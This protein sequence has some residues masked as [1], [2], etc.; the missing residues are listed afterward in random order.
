MSFLYPRTVSVS[1][2][3]S[4]TAIGAV[5]YGGAA[6]PPGAT[7][8]TGLAASIQYKRARSRPDAGLPS[9]PDGSIAGWDIFIR[10]GVKLGDIRDR[11]IITD[12]LGNRYVVVGAYWNSMGF[13]LSTNILEA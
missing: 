5:G 1:R 3:A 6:L 8:F 10:R 12:D 9:D 4:E 11:D 7:L 13:K 2:P